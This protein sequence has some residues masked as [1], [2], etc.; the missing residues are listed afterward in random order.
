MGIPTAA[1][2]AAAAVVVDDGLC[3]AMLPLR[4]LRSTAQRSAEAYPN[5]PHV[6]SRGEVSRAHK[7]PRGILPVAVA[8]RR[9]SA[10]R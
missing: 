1:A 10:A 4:R 6:T 5:P 8:G 9:R 3:R 7:G 2:A